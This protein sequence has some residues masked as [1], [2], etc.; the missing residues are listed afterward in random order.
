MSARRKRP[1]WIHAPA[2]LLLAAL[3]AMAQP[4]EAGLAFERHDWQLACDNTRTCRAAGYPPQTEVLGIS[5]LL[6]RPAGPGAPVGGR[7]MPREYDVTEPPGT[8]RLV[9]DDVDLG[10]LEIDPESGTAEL[11]E[12]Q[13]AALLRALPR[14]SRIAAV[15]DRDGTRWP[16]S[17]RGAAAVLL[18]MDE[19]QGRLGTP[20][21]LVRRGDRDEDAVPPA[22]AAPVLRAAAV[23]PTRPDDRR[24]ADDPSLHAALRGTLPRDDRCDGFDQAPVSVHRLDE[25]RL[26]VSQ[27]CWR[28]AYNEGHG[29]W[30]VRDRAPYRPQLVT[31]SGT[32]Y[33]AGWLWASHK[34]R[35]L[36]DCFSSA[37]WVWD[38]RRFVQAGESSTG[39]CRLMAPGGAWSLPT[40]VSE[41]EAP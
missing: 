11:D 27:L 8:M 14:D 36:G 4:P 39:L 23:P 24:V 7:L 41:V 10:P 18:K 40:L 21:A 16:L 22:L 34:G 33:D 37:S 5:V 29:Y 12:R 30:V 20:G 28:A 31:L 35:G 2:G 25:E 3:P 15:A 38:G 32:D 13:V 1:A 9:V 6:T 19:F 26:L 17:D